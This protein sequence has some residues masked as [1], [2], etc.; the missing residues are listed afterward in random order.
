[1][2]KDELIWTRL[3]GGKLTLMLVANNQDYRV[4]E[5][6]DFAVKVSKNTECARIQGV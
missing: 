6:T 5:N 4:R 3:K 2:V 1:M